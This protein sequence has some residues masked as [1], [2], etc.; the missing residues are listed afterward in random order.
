[1]VENKTLITLS[2]RSH[3]Q[4]IFKKGDCFELKDWLLVSCVS[5]KKNILRWGFTIP[6]YVG[7]AVK[8]NQLRRWCKETIRDRSF[9]KLI[10]GEDLNIVFRK[11]EKCF[12]KNLR[13]SDVHSTLQGFFDIHFS[14]NR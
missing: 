9:D 2:D 11:K 3:F 1:M 7:V 6:K 14:K 8:R 5:N 4:H 12:Y 13:F 10:I